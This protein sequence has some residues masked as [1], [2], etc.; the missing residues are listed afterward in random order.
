MCLLHCRHHQG[1][2]RESCCLQGL[3]L[4]DLACPSPP[5]TDALPL[6]SRLPRL[7]EAEVVRGWLASVSHLVWL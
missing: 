4:L 2:A 6:L 3:E 5:P 7:T 1:Q